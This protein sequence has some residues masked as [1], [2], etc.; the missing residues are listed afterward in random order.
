M[1]DDSYCQAGR[2]PILTREGDPLFGEPCWQLGKYSLRITGSQ[3]MERFTGN[4]P[5]VGICKTHSEALG[6]HRP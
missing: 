3:R 6:A 1:N 2:L 4:Q 5:L